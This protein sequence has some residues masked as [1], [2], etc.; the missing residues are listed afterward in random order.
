MPDG[1]LRRSS[2]LKSPEPS[3][4]AAGPSTVSIIVE[5][6]DE[7]IPSPTKKSKANGASSM[8]RPAAEIKERSTI[9]VEEIDDA[10]MAGPLS[11]SKTD[12]NVVLPSQIIEPEQPLREKERAPSFIFSGPSNATKSTLGL[13]SSA[14]KAP[15]KLRYS[16][17]P[18]KEEKSPEVSNSSSDVNG[19]AFSIPSSKPSFSAT[20]SVTTPSIEIP[21]PIFPIAS[22]SSSAAPAPAPVPAVTAPSAPAPSTP[23][24]TAE[25]KT[26][27]LALP[28]HSLPQYTFEFTLALSSPGAGPSVEKG[29]AAAKGAPVSSLPTFDFTKPSAPP[30]GGFNWAAAGLVPTGLKPGQWKCDCTTTNESFHAKCICCESPRPST[31]TSE[32]SP[33]TPPAPAAPVMGFDFAAAGMK[34]PM[35]DEGSWA[36]DCTTV[37]KKTDSTCICCAEP[38]PSSNAAPASVAPAFASAPPVAPVIGFDFAA[39]GMKKPEATEKWQCGGCMLMNPQE[40]TVCYVCDAPAP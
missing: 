40:N 9:Q 5:D 31:S 36:C 3:T 16:F 24:T 27:V 4:S 18:D 6:V 14:P 23:K 8:L 37:N 22:T 29:K 13:K 35:R 39:A 17:N 33:S 38:R 32:S 20:Q 28:V 7:D 19:N 10:E 2:R 1:G 15:S 26:A 25:I 21:E 12:S 34:M 11:L 30:A